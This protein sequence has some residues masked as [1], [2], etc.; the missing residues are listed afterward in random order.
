MTDN[1][2]VSDG[3]LMG[4]NGSTA[5]VDY[6][7]MA[8]HSAVR[9]SGHTLATYCQ[10]NAYCARGAAA[11]HEWVRVPTTPL[12]EITTGRMEDRPPEPARPRDRIAS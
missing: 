6:V 9:V 5:L 1:L 10:L 7:C 12:G 4:R 2:R 11:E 3:D 8:K